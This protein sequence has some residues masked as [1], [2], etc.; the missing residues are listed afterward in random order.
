[1]VAVHVA[2]H[3]AHGVRVLPDHEPEEFFGY[4]L[5]PCL[6]GEVAL[7]NDAWVSSNVPS[8]GQTFSGGAEISVYGSDKARAMSV[9]STD[10]A[11][12]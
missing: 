1:M 5:D 10:A 4:D 12:D 9:V 6:Q 8:G 11:L 3:A 7:D 2:D